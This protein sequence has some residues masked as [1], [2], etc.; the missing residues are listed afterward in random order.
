M[1]DVHILWGN[2][3]SYSFSSETKNVK[4]VLAKKKPKK[5]EKKT[6]GQNFIVDTCS[7]SERL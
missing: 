2:I 5:N 4:Q 7:T 1:I 6:V 3:F